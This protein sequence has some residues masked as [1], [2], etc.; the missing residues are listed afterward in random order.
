ML[1]LKQPILLNNG[2]QPLS[3][4]T[5]FQEKLLSNYEAL[6]ARVTPKDLVLLTVSPAGL[7]EDL[8]G[9]TTIAVANTS[10]SNVQEV[11]LNVVNNVVNRLLLSQEQNFTYQD[12]IYVS[13]MLRKLGVTDVSQFMRQ[14]RELYQESV[15][16]GRLTSLYENHYEQL[17]LLLAAP[18]EREHGQA[19]APSGE[20]NR[21]LPA[22]RYYLHGEIYQRLQTA[23]LYQAF[24]SVQQNRQL[25]AVNLARNELR[26]T[27]QTRVS[28]ELHLWSMKQSLLSERHL[29]L[30]YAA[31]EGGESAGEEEA[32]PGA[33]PAAP[34]PQAREAR[35]A[36]SA[37]A[38][39]APSQPASAAASPHEETM[40]TRVY[41]VLQ[42]HVNRYETGELLPVPRTEQQVIEQTAEAILL[43]LTDNVLSTQI[44]RLSRPEHYQ[45]WIDLR[46]AV[47]ESMQNTMA[48]YRS[49]HTDLSLRGGDSTQSV[50]LTALYREEESAFTTLLQSYRTVSALR[51]RLEPAAA[52]GENPPAL[53]Y[54]EG[55]A[56]P[57][58]E[59]A[60]E[61]QAPAREP[62]QE[63]REIR[64]VAE[65]A[66]RLLRP[67]AAGQGAAPAAAARRQEVSERVQ[68]ELLRVREREISERF[69]ETVRELSSAETRTVLSVQL[70][71]AAPALARQ[72]LESLESLFVKND[73]FLREGDR[74]LLQDHSVQ[75]GPSVSVTRGET[76]LVF[77]QQAEQGEPA[78]E[79]PAAPAAPQE[80][81][82]AVSERELVHELDR[83]NERNRELLRAVQ[84]EIAAKTPR[85]E[86]APPPEPARV[87][88][89]SLRALEN[90]EAFRRAWEEAPPEQHHPEDTNAVLESVL[91][92]ADPAAREVMRVL[93]EYRENP[94]EAIRSG[95]VR[96]ASAAELTA[97]SR[98][99]ETQRT[100]ELRHLRQVREDAQETVR[101]HV[102][103]VVDRFLEAEQ[104]EAPPP[105]PESRRAALPSMVHRAPEPSV[106]EEL[107]ELLEQ[108][109]LNETH[110]VTETHTVTKE[111]VNQTEVNN[112]RQQMV[113]KSTEDITEM[114][115]RTLAR[116]IGT[117]S[118][119]VYGQME[120][121]LRSERA[122]RGW[123]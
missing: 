56:A 5:V 28:A 53:I 67:G 101:E 116:Q 14:V 82:Q 92:H 19:A 52:P 49:Y 74:F 16:I 48:R 108:R 11:T 46:S 121:R 105:R 51:T 64:R 78:Q 96:P 80:P 1:K 9:M 59:T 71:E 89:D 87:Y 106:S 63:R 31:H 97:V 85:Q 77:Q 23:Q 79:E 26:F 38:G 6:P 68:R 17:R 65:L 12:R 62:A 27:E 70:P 103:H 25:H 2:R 8:G 32:R 86:T 114:I 110:E 69:L 3:F 34:A 61:A 111:Q 118:D 21:P 22:P 7:P 50:S 102:G 119:R 45:Q 123:S 120:R 40:H 112:V 115:N 55:E 18:Q 39:P 98:E 4:S 113:E 73:A 83:I 104:R 44:T 10:Q 43:S 66:D 91:A 47:H 72:T 20:E 30:V 94:A 122:R 93:R 109:R 99:I 15:S 35:P 54:R 24:R 90:P 41:A 100:Q 117:I 76:N 107:L 58:G 57:E 84:Q 29:E 60:P 95:L 13:T 36:S 33:A 88:R 37:A 42:N 75:N 81:A